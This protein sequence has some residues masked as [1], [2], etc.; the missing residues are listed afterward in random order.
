MKRM[1]GFDGEKIISVPEKLWAFMFS[2]NPGLF[3]LYITHIGYFPKAQ[4]HYRKRKNGCEDN[5]LIYCTKG[6]GYF[7]VGD[8]QINLTANQYII[9]PATK[10]AM[11]YG[12]NDDDP[13]TIFW[14]H[15]KASDIADFN[16]SLAKF[17]AFQLNDIPYSEKTIHTWS[18]IYDSLDNGFSVTN[19][20]NASF[21]LYYLLCLFL[22]HKQHLP[23]KHSSVPDIIDDTITYM[24]TV[25]HT[26][27]KVSAFAERH[28]LSVPYFATLFR[29]KTGMAPIDYFIHL[30]MQKAC[31]LLFQT[32]LQIKNI[33][34]ELGYADPYLFS[35]LFKKYMGTS[36]LQYRT[37]TR[38]H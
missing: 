23:V 35:R 19:L 34:V 13:W 3:R 24:K 7:V 11:Y 6:G 21:S 33:A 15:F 27:V 12:A 37:N 4:G 29:K 1:L 9:V 28:F 16:Y 20:C 8:E 25:L 22:F 5:I 18:Q 17:G 38:K 14:V 32:S 2:S 26:K 36:P 30:K 10:T 31:Q